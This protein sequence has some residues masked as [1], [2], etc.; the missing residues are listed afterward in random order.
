[1]RRSAFPIIALLVFL[2]GSPAFAQE[3]D[4]RQL[5]ADGMRAFADGRYVEAAELFGR[6]YALDPQGELLKNESV[7]WY[8]AGRCTEAVETAHQFILRGKPTDAERAEAQSLIGACKVKLA[9]EALDAGSFDLAEKLLD[10][11]DATDPD[12]VLADRTALVRVELA[13]RRAEAAEARA[14]EARAAKQAE[15][16]DHSRQPSLVALDGTDGT[17]GAAPE[18][19][20]D[21]EATL[22]ASESAE[23]AGGGGPLIAV[24]AVTIAGAVAYHLVMALLVE[25]NFEEVAAAGTDRQEYNRLDR[26]L[27]IAN[28]LVPTLYGLGGAVTATGIFVQFSGSRANDEDQVVMLGLS[29][30]F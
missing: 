5:N 11:V 20:T 22:D 15:E 24:G 2:C 18:P 17:R 10:D 19:Q 13:K 16:S 21:R 30:R 25:P 6:A 26:S 3:V 12:P 8:K 4:V 7:A 23:S 28:I 14:A 29:G 27:R 9:G 1:M